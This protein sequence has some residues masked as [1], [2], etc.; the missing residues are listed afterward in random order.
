MLMYY[1]ATLPEPEEKRKFEKLYIAHRQVMYY[2]AYRILRNP[3]DSEDVVHQAFLRLLEHL[4]KVDEGDPGRARSFLVTMTENAAI[5]LHRRRKL[6][7]TVSPEDI[8]AV[9]A[10]PA[11]SSAFVRAFARLPVNYSSVLRLKYS[12]GYDNTEIGQLLG[13]SEE[14]VR[15]RLSRGR[16]R[17]AQLLEEE[18]ITV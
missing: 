5:D 9:P 2:A 1:T 4:D 17:L 10:D 15:Q 14:A 16:K 6:Q 12:C 3:Q 11:E 18:A 8:P 13:L 7:R